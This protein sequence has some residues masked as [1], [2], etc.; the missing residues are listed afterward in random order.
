[1]PGAARNVDGDDSQNGQ[2]RGLVGID[3]GVDVDLVVG[4]V[5]RVVVGSVNGVVVSGVN[6]VVVGGVVEVVIDN[7]VGAVG[8]RR[9][10]VYQRLVIFSL[11]TECSRK[12]SYGKTIDYALESLGP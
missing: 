1:M 12:V 10:D 5:N 9:I 3:V 4:G 8:A 6:G 2:V 7:V 11:G